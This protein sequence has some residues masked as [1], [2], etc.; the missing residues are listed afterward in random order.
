MIIARNYLKINSGQKHKKFSGACQGAGLFFLYDVT[1]PP[2]PL[3]TAP[4]RRGD[5]FCRRRATRLS[6]HNRCPQRPRG[7]SPR[8]YTPAV[9]LY[10]RFFIRRGI[11]RFTLLFVLKRL[12]RAL[13]CLST[14]LVALPH[15]TTHRRPRRPSPHITTHRRPRRRAVAAFLFHRPPLIISPPCFA[16]V[17]RLPRP[18]HSRAKG[19]SS[20]LRYKYNHTKKHPQKR[21]AFEDACVCALAS[22]LRCVKP[23]AVL[24]LFSVH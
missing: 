15:I 22:D 8:A 21:L 14:R 11:Y 12:F 17:I 13:S 18:L 7:L 4:P 9:A 24:R 2:P 20:P 23:F 3:T 16:V 5:V 6:S 1:I 19:L 10:G